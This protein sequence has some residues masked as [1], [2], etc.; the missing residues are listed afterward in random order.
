MLSGYA[1][2]LLSIV[3]LYLA[4]ASFGVR[5]AAGSWLAMTG[6]ILVGL[7]PF[8][9]CGI[10]LG[11]LLTRDSM[12]PAMGGITA[13]FALLGG[14]WG[15]VV[16]QGVLRT[17]TELL[18]SYWLVQ[19]GKSALGGGAGRSKAWIVIAVWTRRPGPARRYRLPT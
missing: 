6:L 1:V 19:A 7:I 14:A 3:L 13:L 10:V 18:P 12:G 11:H 2:A 16:N 5:L 17:V 15:P 4:G 8:A 9:V